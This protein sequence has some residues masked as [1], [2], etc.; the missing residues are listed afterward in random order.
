MFGFLSLHATTCKRF[1]KQKRSL[2]PCFQSLERNRSL[3]LHIVIHFDF[4][5]RL[6][7]LNSVKIIQI[8][9]VGY[10]SQQQP[11]LC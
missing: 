5:F 8:F 2:S 7:D 10:K 9:L 4:I 1:Y 3:E 11:F 6:K